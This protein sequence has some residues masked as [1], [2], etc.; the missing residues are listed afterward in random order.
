MSYFVCG[1]IWI[2]D[3]HSV[4]TPPFAARVS[5]RALQCGMSLLLDCNIMQ[6]LVKDMLAAKQDETQ[7]IPYLLTDSPLNNTSDELISPT[8]LVGPEGDRAFRRNASI[9][10]GFF[11][12]LLDEQL[13]QR[14]DLYVIDSF[15]SS[16]PTRSLPI[17]NLEAELLS[18][19]ASRDK[20]FFFK[21]VLRKLE[22]I[23]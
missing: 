15:D 19:W 5:V 18:A 3:I 21:L 4:D 20:D 6:P 10:S 2:P 14:V 16:I 23:G 1:S 11:R 8:V 13:V 9:L 17:T 7:R 22:P 12:S